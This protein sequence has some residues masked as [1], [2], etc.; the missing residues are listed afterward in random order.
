MPASIVNLSQYAPVRERSD[1]AVLDGA[2]PGA[3]FA[4]LLTLAILTVSFYEPHLRP[5]LEIGWRIAVSTR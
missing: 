4:T 1:V 3:V 5:C 2:G